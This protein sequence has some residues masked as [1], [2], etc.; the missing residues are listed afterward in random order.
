ML[1][2]VTSFFC[3]NEQSFVVRDLEPNTKY[4]FAVRLHIEQLSSPWSPV[5]YQTTLPEGKLNAFFI[6]CCFVEVN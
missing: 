4:E 3:R 5:V 6:L 1:K 2:F